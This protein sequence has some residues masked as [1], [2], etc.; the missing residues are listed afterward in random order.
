[1]LLERGKLTKLFLTVL[2]HQEDQQSRRD[3]G[4]L[5]EGDSRMIGCSAGGA[6]NHG[7]AEWVPSPRHFPPLQLVACC[8]LVDRMYFACREA[9]RVVHC[10]EGAMLALL[11]G[12]YDEFSGAT[13]YYFLNSNLRFK[14]HENL[15]SLLVL[16]FGDQNALALFQKFVKH[17]IASSSPV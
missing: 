15:Y 11:H 5:V 4:R 17:S 2:F 6:S 7:A 3:R 1:M 16:Q 14:P 8:P 12:N 9:V 13:L 10:C